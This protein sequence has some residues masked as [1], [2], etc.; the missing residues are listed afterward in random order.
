MGHYHAAETSL[1]LH[2]S[3]AWSPVSGDLN[4]P[5]L[6]VKKSRKATHLFSARIGYGLY[7]PGGYGKN[8]PG[9]R[10]NT[11]QLM[12]QDMARRGSGFGEQS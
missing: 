10:G 9:Q 3:A 7:Q 5:N 4:P 8:T 12:A 11:E 1:L 2:T 6:V